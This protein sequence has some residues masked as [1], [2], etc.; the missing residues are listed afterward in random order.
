MLLLKMEHH[1]MVLMNSKT[2]VDLV[3][4]SIYSMLLWFLPLLVVLGVMDH[5]V[6]VL[7][8]TFFNPMFISSGDTGPFATSLMTIGMIN[9]TI[10][11]GKWSYSTSWL[12]MLYSV[13]SFCTWLVVL[14]SDLVTSTIVLHG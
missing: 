6:H 10:H 3:S 9:V 4:G 13:D 8:V 5:H 14:V 1:K 2:L 11:S 7:G 12:P